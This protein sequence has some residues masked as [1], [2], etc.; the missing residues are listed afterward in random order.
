MMRRGPCPCCHI[1]PPCLCDVKN[2]S[3]PEAAQAWV[4]ERANN[5]WLQAQVIK[6]TFTLLEE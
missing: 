4:T 6:D 5:R 2:L 3:L 1:L